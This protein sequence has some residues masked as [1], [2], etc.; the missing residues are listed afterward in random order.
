MR[1][2]GAPEV[3]CKFN[4][5]GLFLV[6]V[7]VFQFFLTSK[8]GQHGARSSR[9]MSYNPISI[10]DLDFTDCSLAAVPHAFIEGCTVISDSSERYAA[11]AP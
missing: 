11:N 8:L 7:I 10:L 9:A 2:S 5:K 6:L 4:P 3:G 1:C